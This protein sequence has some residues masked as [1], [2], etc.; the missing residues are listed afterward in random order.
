MKNPRCILIT[1]ASSGIGEALAHYFAMPGVFLA[2]SGRD[3]A[4]LDKV[5][6]VC[7]DKG[8]EV[9]AELV[10]VC[11]RD[12]MADW[13]KRT[14]QVQPLDLVIANAGISGDSGSNSID[15]NE[16]L[17][18]DIFAVNFAGVL[19]TIF[20]ALTPMRKRQRGQLALVSSMAGFRGL[21]S[22]P[23]YS[24]SKVM[25]KAYGEALHGVLAK[26]GIGV[27]VI[28]PGFV[29]SRITAKNKFPMPLLMKAPK[30][31]RIIAGGL[32]K[33]RLLIAFPWPF[34]AFMW[35]LNLLPP[36]WANKLLSRLP[37]KG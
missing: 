24:T 9:S 21:P 18:R 16:N 27:S 4:R 3:Q 7:R 36:C 22:A 14:D 13:I 2:L 32:A 30:A 37:K 34:V 20:P 25:V 29:E 23:A 26:E 15:L 19:N 11:D 6:Q 8:A 1:G 33:N 5:A 12:A 17:T 10:D 28:C 31:A 35:S